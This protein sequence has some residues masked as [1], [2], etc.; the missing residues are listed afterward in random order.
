MGA[1]DEVTIPVQNLRCFPAV[2]WEKPVW[3]WLPP[4]PFYVCVSRS[5]LP[6]S[7]PHV[8]DITVTRLPSLS[9]EMENVRD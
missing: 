4:A 8:F 1:S 9:G 3:F 7:V 5:A 6:W 2:Y